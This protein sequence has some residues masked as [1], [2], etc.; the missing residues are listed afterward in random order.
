MGRVGTLTPVTPLVTGYRGFA[1]CDGAGIIY[2]DE[3]HV[4]WVAV[5]MSYLSHPQNAG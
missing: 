3:M 1:C 4:I 5:S 2:P